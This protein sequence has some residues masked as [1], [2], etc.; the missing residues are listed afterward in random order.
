MFTEDDFLP[1][2]A[3][4]QYYYCQ[5]RAAL[6]LIDQVW[7]DNVHTVEGSII[8]E[9]VHRTAKESRQEL[10]KVRNLPLHSFTHGLS[11]L[12]DCVEFHAD[13][14][15]IPVKGLIGLWKLIPIEYKHGKV[16]NELE[17]EVQL[18]AQ[19][20]CLEEM[21]GCSINV[22]YIFY[23]D[24]HRRKEVQ[25]TEELRNKVSEGAQNIHELTKRG[26]VPLPEKSKKCQ[27]CSLNYD[28]LPKIKDSSGNYI[29][30]LWTDAEVGEYD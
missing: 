1:I 28:C 9:R 5:R 10:I 21:L 25:F 15:G 3:L 30:K 2:S 6:M 7:S 23:S 22:G 14:A 20:I 11:G 12:A 8:H 24:D 29:K 16:R 13:K 4:S 26:I 18:C 17:Y 27:E 19:V